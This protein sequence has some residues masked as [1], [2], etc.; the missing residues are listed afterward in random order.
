MHFQA[1][2]N[3]QASSR[4]ALIFATTHDDFSRFSTHQ[5]RFV[6]RPNPGKEKKYVNEAFGR[7]KNADEWALEIE[8]R[9]EPETTRSRDGK[10]LGDTIM[11]VSAASCSI[12]DDLSAPLGF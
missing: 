11:F 6:V 8:R 4:V 5:R 10:L 7:R 9:Q 3:R 1:H 2:S 12:Q